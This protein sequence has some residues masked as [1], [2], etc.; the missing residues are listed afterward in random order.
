MSTFTS[1]LARYNTIACQQIMPIPVV[2][3]SA[4]SKVAP[5]P[6]CSLELP[7]NP[8]Q[9]PYSPPTNVLINAVEYPPHFTAHPGQICSNNSGFI[10]PGYLVCDGSEVS[11]VTYNILFNIIGTYYGDGNTVNT[12]NLP[13]LVDDNNPNVIYMIKYKLCEDTIPPAI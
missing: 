8:Q 3:Q 11:R 5:V 9:E 7:F 4:I 12:F 13:V 10:P 1:K 2:M 6:I